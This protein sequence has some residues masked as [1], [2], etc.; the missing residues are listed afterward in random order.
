M[1]DK[2]IVELDLFAD[3]AGEYYL[4]MYDI[5]L[6]K[7]VRV[8]ISAILSPEGVAG[9]VLTKN[10]SAAF[11]ASWKDTDPPKIAIVNAV[12]SGAYQVVSSN[13]VAV[14]FNTINVND[15]AGL[16]VASPIITFP[17]GSYLLKAEIPIQCYPD[18]YLRAYITE[19]PSGTVLTE[20]PSNR[21][22]IAS[23]WVPIKLS[24]D[25]KLVVTE[26][27]VT[28]DIAIRVAS[29]VVDANVRIGYNVSSINKV[30]SGS[31][32]IA[33]LSILKIS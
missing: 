5:N 15:I 13:G 2:K 26:E 10:S 14:I 9:Q 30:D 1:A 32:T 22:I 25:Y 27:D 33:Q 6:D 29:S 12:T 3:A 23:H 4:A 11:D 19:E 20:G 21:A 16:S 28:K 8:P 7:T 18:S 17:V 24:V 31:G